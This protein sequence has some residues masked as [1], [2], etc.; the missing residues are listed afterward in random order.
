MIS[1]IDLKVYVID[2]P[3][4]VST[5]HLNAQELFD[6]DLEGLVLWFTKKY[7]VDPGVLPNLADVDTLSFPSFNFL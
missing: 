3:Q 1:K 5:L 6:R 4:M 2:F 7:G